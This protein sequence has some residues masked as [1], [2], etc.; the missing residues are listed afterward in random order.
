M[1]LEAERCGLRPDLSR[2]AA[3]SRRAADLPL[4]A[5]IHRSPL[6]RRAHHVS[7][8]EKVSRSWDFRPYFRSPQISSRPGGGGDPRPEHVGRTPVRGWGVGQHARPPPVT[9]FLLDTLAE[10]VP[11]SQMLTRTGLQGGSD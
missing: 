7:G 10:T 9:R 4:K 1:D 2:G 11:A 6:C 3:D 8:A 5:R